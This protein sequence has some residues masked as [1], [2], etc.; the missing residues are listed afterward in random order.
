[1]LESFECDLG[2]QLERETTMRVMTAYVAHELNHPLGT[3]IN[4]VNTLSRNITRSVVRPMEVEDQLK[5]IKEEAIRA[6]TIIKQLR[7]LT[8][9]RPPQ[10]YDVCLIDVC[11]DTMARLMPLAEIKQVRVRLR[12]STGS[13]RISGV[14]ELLETA[15]YNLLINS[16]AALDDPNIKFRR[17][18]IR[19]LNQQDTTVVQVFDNGCGLPIDMG[20]KIFE[21]FVSTRLEGGGL[22]LAIAGDIVRWHRGKLSCRPRKNGTCM[23]MLLPMN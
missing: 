14:K 3:I 18:T 1:M 9:R 4:L 6:T 20:E 8:D 19:I 11:K 12:V 15:L 22:G 17:L 13:T 2:R 16:V 21:P 10:K 5:T 7:M 23:E